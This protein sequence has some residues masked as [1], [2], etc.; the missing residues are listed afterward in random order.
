M[1]LVL[2]CPPRCKGAACFP[3]SKA[4]RQPIGE[5]AFYYHYYEFPG[6]HSV[7]KHYGVVT[8]RYKLVRFYGTDS[9]YSELFDLKADPQEMRDVISDPGYA[10]TRKML[11]EELARLRRSLEVPDQDPPEGKRS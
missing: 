11:E 3:F 4:N 7:K 2:P 9:D 5:R 10:E 6:A 8:D 1:Q